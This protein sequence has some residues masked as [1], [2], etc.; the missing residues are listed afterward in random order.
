MILVLRRDRLNE[1]VETVIPGFTG[2]D[3][4]ASFGDGPFDFVWFKYDKMNVR[5]F[6]PTLSG[7]AINVVKKA[8]KSVTQTVTPGEQLN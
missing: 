3:Y 4:R 1:I 5:Q 2:T 6:V 8:V 7:T